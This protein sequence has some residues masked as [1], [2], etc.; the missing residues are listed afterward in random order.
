MERHPARALA[1]M[2]IRKLESDDLAAVVAVQAKTPEASSWTRGDY[3]SLAGDPSGLVL[4]A[5]LETRIVGFAAFHRVIDEA[6]LRNM[7][8]DPDYQRKG[9]GRELLA[10]ALRRLSEQGVRRF[11]LEVRASNVAARKLYR[12]VGFGLCYRRKDYYDNP[13]EDAF[14]LSLATAPLKEANR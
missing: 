7:A 5:T 14:V 9:V 12:S 4:V 10:E 13:R 3:A 8:V 11:Y 6:E 1:A 2:R